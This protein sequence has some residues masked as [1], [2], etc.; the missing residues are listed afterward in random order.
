MIKLTFSFKKI[1]IVIIVFLFIFIVN[2]LITTGFFRSIENKFDGII[3]KKIELSG[4]EDITVSNTDHFAIIS[5]TNRAGYPPTEEQ[6][7]GLYLMD[8]KNEYFTV[9]HLTTD[10]SKP[11][12]PH[13]ISM[14]KKD[15]TYKIFSVNHTSEGHSIEVF[16]FVEHQLSYIKTLTDKTMI[17]PNDVVLI[18]EHKFYFTNDHKYTKGIGRLMEDYA[19]LSLSNVVYF[20][21]ENYHEVANGIAYANGINFDA[22][23]NLLYVAS[24]RKFLVKVYTR[25]NDGTLNF[26]E[27]IPC[28]TGVDNIELDTNGKLWIGGHPNLLR[29]AAY[30]KGK[31]ETSPSEIITIDY[32]GLNDYTIEQIYLDDGTTMSSSSV[33]APFEELILTGNVKDDSFLILKKEN[34]HH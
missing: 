34:K 24:P 7:G 12:A 2:I 9:K 33:A 29:F 32:R 19:G 26:I 14:I 27:D 31:K 8:L 22:K 28:G 25:N 15:S 5:S 6:H 10:F 30:A 20:D 16:K 17:S 11:F 13:G 23:R 21:G 1:G 18:D 4:A 3:V